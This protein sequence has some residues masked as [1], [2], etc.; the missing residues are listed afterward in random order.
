MLN[1]HWIPS[2]LIAV[3]GH[4]HP[5]QIESPERERPGRR[6]ALAKMEGQTFHPALMLAVMPP[7]IPRL[8]PLREAHGNY[9]EMSA[10]RFRR[11]VL[12]RDFHRPK[13]TAKL[14]E[15]L[16]ESSDFASLEVMIAK[17]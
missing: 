3:S 12:V 1:F 9:A 6:A 7:P 15:W 8:A 13:Q 5:L 14:N 2:P 11:V 16:T 17:N 4:H 10:V